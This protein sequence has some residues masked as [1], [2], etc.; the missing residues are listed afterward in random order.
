MI[1]FLTNRGLLHCVHNSSRPQLQRNRADVCLLQL[2]L[3]VTIVKTLLWQCRQEQ[4]VC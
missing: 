4:W 2:Y 1:N 3:M